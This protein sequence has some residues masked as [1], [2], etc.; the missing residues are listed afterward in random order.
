MI[1]DLHITQLQETGRVQLIGE[2][3]LAEISALADT[4][5]LTSQEVFI[6]SG[7]VETLDIHVATKKDDFDPDSDYAEREEAGEFEEMP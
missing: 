2:T 3:S 1:S 4:L 7:P 6:G 5:G